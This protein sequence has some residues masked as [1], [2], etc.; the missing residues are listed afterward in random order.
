M[1]H[2]PQFHILSEKSW[3]IQDEKKLISKIH[4][5][6]WQ[7]HILISTCNKTDIFYVCIHMA[8]LCTLQ[9]TDSSQA[10][11]VKSYTQ[12]KALQQRTVFSFIHTYHF[13]RISFIPWNSYFYLT[14][15]KSLIP[16][17]SHKI[18]RVPPKSLRGLAAGTIQQF[19]VAFWSVCI[20]FSDIQTCG[21]LYFKHII[22]HQF[23]AI[24]FLHSVIV[25]YDLRWRIVSF[26][27]CVFFIQ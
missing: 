3:P 17:F 18:K 4:T 9:L 2:G 16:S 24:F 22:V 7:H 25:N 1:V 20:T 27:I 12:Q 21:A 19:N 14:N 15:G 8:I 11:Y 6:R 13:T 23:Y 5:S 10:C 26:D